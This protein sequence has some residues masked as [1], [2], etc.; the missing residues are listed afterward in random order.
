MKFP[1]KVIFGILVTLS[2]L[3]CRSTKGNGNPIYSN[4]TPLEWSV[5][6]SESI[7]ARHDSLI[8]STHSPNK[9][10]YDIAW[11]A[12]AIAQLS[13]K[14][15]N[16]KYFQYMK[17]YMD[18]YINPDG[19]ARYYAR[20]EY[21]LDRIRPA[22]NLFQLWHKT[23]DYKYK[24]ALQ[25]H[26]QQL[27]THPRTSEGG[28][29][30]KKIYPHQ[31]WLDGLFMASPFMAQYGAE[32]NEPIWYDEAIHQITL[33][34][35]HTL[36]P[37]TGLLYHGWDESRQQNWSNRQTGQ[38]PNFW[39]RAMGW[40]TMTIV[41]VL[42]FIPYNH[43][44]RAEIIDILKKTSD[45]LLK[46]RDPT[47]HLWYQVSDAGNRKGNYLEAS[48]SGMFAYSFAKG[49]INGYLPKSFLKEAEATYQG[50][51]SRLI[52]IDNNGLINLEQTCGGAGLGGDR[53]GSFNYYISEKT[54]QNDSKGMAA[55]ILTGLMLNNK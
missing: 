1:G 39:S 9:W 24:T 7:I 8:K 16:D 19:T 55:F 4:I 5:R 2:I 27:K 38:S 15:G 33:V 52:N 20:E 37:K 41:D 50:I 3:G 31:M 6:M 45:A 40:Y 47:S 18:Y 32:F 21:N 28:F 11:L 25:N 26:I 23:G 51:I 49:A 34:Y 35:Q 42:D 14:T 54:T 30:H 46:V 22:I 43:P 12:G 10:Q 48:G 17:T 13:D 44:G 29:W 53:D 36:D